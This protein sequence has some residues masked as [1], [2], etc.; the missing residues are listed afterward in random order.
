MISDW[1]R[2]LFINTD[3]NFQYIKYFSS[4]TEEGDDKYSFKGY[5]IIDFD[6]RVHSQEYTYI[7]KITLPKAP[8]VASPYA[9]YWETDEEI[10]SHYTKSYTTIEDWREK[11]PPIIGKK[12]QPPILLGNSSTWEDDKEI[13]FGTSLD[14]AEILTSPKF[15]SLLE[16]FFDTVQDLD[17]RRKWGLT[18][19]Q[20]YKNL[21]KKIEWLAQSCGVELDSIL[22][23][24]QME[25]DYTQGSFDEFEEWYE[26]V[27]WEKM[28]LMETVMEYSHNF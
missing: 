1:A 17:E 25:Y 2:S 16:N 14:P 19:W 9:H 8:Y 10:E 4:I 11:N 23:I 5:A 3:D 12:S 7:N 24:Y 21:V 13:E 28:N 20:V 15:E 27:E 6:W 22:D 18:E 26:Y